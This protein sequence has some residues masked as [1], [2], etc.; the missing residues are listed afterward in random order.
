MA[1][2][3][4]HGGDRAPSRKSSL[5]CLL[6]SN[7]PELLTGTGILELTHTQTEQQKDQTLP[8]KKENKKSPNSPKLYIFFLVQLKL[9][10]LPNYRQAISFEHRHIQ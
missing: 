8:E 9:N 10:L 3:R 2:M 7:W 1:P 5:L 6:I 4:W